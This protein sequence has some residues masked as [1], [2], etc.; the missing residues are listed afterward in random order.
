M[1][2]PEKS[3][4]K[5]ASRSSPTGKHLPAGEKSVQTTACESENKKEENTQRTIKI[6]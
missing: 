2:N 5:R 3:F 1:Y 4:V 6:I